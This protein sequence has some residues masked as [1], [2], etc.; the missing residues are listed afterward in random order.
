[1]RRTKTVAAVL[2]VIGVLAQ[3]PPAVATPAAAQVSA[4][5][6]GIAWHGCSTGPGDE[7]GGQLDAAGAQCGEVTV[8]VDHDDPHGRRTTLAMSRIK[9]SDPARRRGVLMINPGGP[10]GPGMPQVLL[11]QYMPDVAARYD[12]VGLDPRFVGRSSPMRCDWKTSTF[13]RSAGPGL[14][15]FGESVAL[16]KD[17]ARGCSSLDHD[18]LRSASTRNNARDMDAVRIALGERKI[19]Y[20]GV[21]YGTYLGAVYLQMFGSRA[22]RFVLDSAVD[23]DV[24]GPG[25]LRPTARASAAA[26]RDWAGGA[27]GHGL[28]ATAEE[29]LATVNGV[30]RSAERRPLSVGKYT[31]DGHVLPYLLF[32]GVYKDDPEYRAAFTDSVRV[33]ADAARG[34]PV[35]PTP[36]LEEVLGGLATGEGDAEDRAGAPTVCADRK[37]SRDP[38]TYYRDIQAHRAAEPLFGPLARNISPCAF[39][40]VTPAEPTTRI[41]NGSP[42]LMLGAD[43]DPAT[44]R[45]GQLAMHRALAGSRMVTLEGRFRHGVFLTAGNACADTAVRDHLVG[46]V[47][48]ATDRTCR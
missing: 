14:R 16:A 10:G 9:A 48:P 29:V 41:A 39:W 46:G 44:P 47:L 34:I 8:P 21:S 12:L 32:V 1:M 5:A 13:L 43:G 6:S 31:V 37:A 19:S 38:A 11:G 4:P 2:L 40:P 35:A 42:V 25:L 22:D 33:L 7:V 45:P 3:A 15:S 27:V 17:L 18:L 28:G 23:P 20:Y 36:M 24:F 26:L 30:A